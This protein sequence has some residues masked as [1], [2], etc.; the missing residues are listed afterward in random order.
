MND[1]AMPPEDDAWDDRVVCPDD[2]CT[3]TLNSAG[4]CGTCEVTFEAHAR[5]TQ[6]PTYP[7]DITD[8]SAETPP[9]DALPSAALTVASEDSEDCEDSAKVSDDREP[10]DDDLC[11]GVFDAHGRC[12]TCGAE[13]A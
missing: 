8:E 10:C 11:V 3:G 7:T 9:D 5:P 13:R 6:D 4:H 1:I 12:G 2:L